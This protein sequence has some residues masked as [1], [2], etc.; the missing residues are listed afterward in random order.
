MSCY[1]ISWSLSEYKKYHDATLRGILL[2]S[3][4]KCHFW[5][6]VSQGMHAMVVSGRRQLDE[7]EQAGSWDGSPGAQRPGWLGARPQPSDGQRDR[8]GWNPP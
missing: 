2:L 7:G 6:F 8:G 3:I 1:H 4:Q 5:V